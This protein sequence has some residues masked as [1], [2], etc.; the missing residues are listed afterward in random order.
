L[1]MWFIGIKSIAKSIIMAMLLV[2]VLMIFEKTINKLE[3]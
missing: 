2:G 3:D 1:I